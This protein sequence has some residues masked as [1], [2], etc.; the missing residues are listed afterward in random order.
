MTQF[1]QMTKKLINLDGKFMYAQFKNYSYRNMKWKFWQKKSF[2][3]FIAPL[4]NFSK[5]LGL[6]VFQFPANSYETSKIGTFSFIINF[7]HY[8]CRVFLLFTAKHQDLNMLHSRIYFI[9]SEFVTTISYTIVLIIYI[10]NVILRK[11]FFKL[12]ILFK[13]FD[14]QVRKRY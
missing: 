1:Q 14:E 3:D 4:L 10:S 9:V 13:Q 8:L 7:C 6:C 5:F 11:S 2:Y 12:L